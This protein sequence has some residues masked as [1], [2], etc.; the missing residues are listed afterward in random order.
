MIFT[1]QGNYPTSATF[2]WDF[3]PR[4]NF[5]QFNGKKPPPIAWSAPGKHYITLSVTYKGCTEQKLDSINISNLSVGV[6]AGPDQRINRGQEV[7]LAA[8]GGS[9]YY[10]SVR[11]SS[12][13]FFQPWGQR[14]TVQLREGADTV[15]HRVR[16]RDRQGC[17]GI[18]SMLVIISE[19]EQPINFI[20]PNGDDINDA[21]DLANLNPDQDAELK[22]CKPLGS[23]VYFESDY[24]NA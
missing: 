7:S 12:G 21:F 19:G 22:R 18:D 8:T 13:G 20:S 1:A 23:E 9:I 17:E 10:W 5:P 11:G 2:A 24:D 3:G 15:F 14:T 6:D 16:V 4:A